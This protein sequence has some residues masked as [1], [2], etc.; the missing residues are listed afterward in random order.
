[1]IVYVNYIS[2]VSFVQKVWNMYSQGEYSVTSDAVSR[3]RMPGISRRNRLH[4]ASSSVLWREVC[5]NS[6]SCSRVINRSSHGFSLGSHNGRC[7][8]CSE[9]LFLVSNDFQHRWHRK[10]R[11]CRRLRCCLD[12][13]SFLCM[14]NIAKGATRKLTLAD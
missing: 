12:I 4:H 10:E 14:P 13:I 1:M 5:S 3:D 8:W 6:A 2:I 7:V 9:T 11:T